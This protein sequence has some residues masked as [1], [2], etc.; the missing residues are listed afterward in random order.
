MEA[1]EAFQVP[2]EAQT[3]PEPLPYL[4]EAKL[5]AYDINL[6]VAIRAGTMTAPSSICKS[7]AK[8]LYWNFKQQLVHHTVTGC[9]MQVSLSFHSISQCLFLTDG[10]AYLWYVSLVICLVVVPSVVKKTLNMVVC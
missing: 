4:R 1:L 6:D 10:S 2:N 7:N 9:N 5:S 3:D 8:Y